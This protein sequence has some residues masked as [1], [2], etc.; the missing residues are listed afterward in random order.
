[1]IKAY[2]CQK[3]RN[4]SYFIIYLLNKLSVAKQNYNIEN[5]KPLIIIVL[6]EI[7]RVYIKKVAE[8]NIYIN[9]KNLLHFIITK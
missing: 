2:F 7:W 4:K 1:M 9:Y 8:L 5:K 6:L 3:Y